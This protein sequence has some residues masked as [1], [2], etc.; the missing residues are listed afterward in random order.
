MLAARLPF[1]LSLELL[2]EYRAVLLRE[3]IQRRHRLRE[4]E[5]EVILT[6]IA[7]NAIFRE[8][9]ETEQAG[10]PEADPGDRHL[11]RL[12]AVH[13]AS[14]LVT[15]DRKLQRALREFYAVYSPAEFVRLMS[16]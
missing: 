2:A 11:I 1:L 15:G 12:L 6:E 4:Q 8:P 16:L 3:P 14:S 13:A 9:E 5:V 7:A 10:A